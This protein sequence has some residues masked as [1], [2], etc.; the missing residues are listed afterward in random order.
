V[1]DQT[2][3]IGR[4]LR[5]ALWNLRYEDKPRTMWVDAICIDQENLDE[6]A[7]QVTFMGEIYGASSQ[8]VIWLGD[9]A[10]EVEQG[11][12]AIKAIGDAAAEARTSGSRIE[13]GKGPIFDK[14]KND[15]TIEN[16]FSISGWWLRVWTAQE[17]LFSK[18]AVLVNGRFRI[19]WDFFCDAVRYGEELQIWEVI[20]LG[21]FTDPTFMNLHTIQKLKAIQ[22]AG[23]T[24]QALLDCLILTRR[25]EATDPRDKIFAV[26]GLVPGELW[27]V[28]IQPDY[29][30]PANIVFR[31]ATR[32]II[33]ASGTLDIL[34]LCSPVRQSDV[35]E[36]PS[37]VSDWSS[38]ESTAQP[39]LNDVNGSRRLTHASREAKAEP[40]WEANGQV[41]VL[42][43]SI[44]DTVGNLSKVL[45]PADEDAW[46]I[47]IDFDDPDMG[48]IET[49]KGLKTIA[50]MAYENLTIVVLH[51]AVFIEWENF[52]KTLK[53]N[54]PDTRSS[55]PMD[56][57][58]QT[59]CTGYTSEEG[60][61][62][63]KQLFQEWMKTLSP[64]R[65]LKGWK[66]DKAQAIFRLT[67]LIGYIRRTWNGYGDFLAYT[68]QAIERRIGSTEQGYLCLLPKAVELGDRIVILKGGRVPVVLRPL[69]DGTFTLVGE[70]FVHGFMDGE[71][72]NKEALTEI[73]IK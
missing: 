18:S 32:K 57:Y 46:D 5:N 69:Q 42:E 45:L 71:A 13:P 35:G 29:R 51:L 40:R 19:D 22:K 73:K 8:T 41:L 68:V 47:D 61:D 17:I 36:L 33:E 2:L 26:L 23:K 48:V 15:T 52:V 37:W 55:D 11:Y 20:Y 58:W 3:H 9:N 54:N 53:P 25:R 21:S 43:G 14:Y 60:Y 64:I 38:T 65:T 4:N 6:R 16:A 31:D 62:K 1:N 56:I 7:K 66:I 39:L 28:G 30:S 27:E 10:S 34:G 50:G 67:G 72:F 59:L 70:A 63:M 44:F 12:K 24:A 49:L